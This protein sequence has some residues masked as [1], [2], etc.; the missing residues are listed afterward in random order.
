MDLDNNIFIGSVRIDNPL[1][2]QGALKTNFKGEWNIADDA[3]ASTCFDCGD[4]GRTLRI[5]LSRAGPITYA[6]NTGFR[7]PNF[8]ALGSV[9]SFCEGRLA[10]GNTYS[11]GLFGRTP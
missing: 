4:G 2:H 8:P 7:M 9:F 1:Y 5:D 3:R 10:L 6:S 11:R